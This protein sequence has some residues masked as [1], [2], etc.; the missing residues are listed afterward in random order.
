MWSQEKS[1]AESQVSAS[2]ALPSE[3]RFG[4][5]EGAEKGKSLTTVADGQLLWSPQP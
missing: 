2:W 4:E 3:R 1:A 5:A